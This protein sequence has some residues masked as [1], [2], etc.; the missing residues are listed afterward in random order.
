MLPTRTGDWKLFPRGTGD[1]LP[2]TEL[3]LVHMLWAIHVGVVPQ[4]EVELKLQGIHVFI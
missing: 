3:A 1:H 2:A 4:L